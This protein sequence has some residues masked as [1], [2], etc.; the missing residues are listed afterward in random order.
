VPTRTTSCSTAPPSSATTFSS[1]CSVLWLLATWGFGQYISAFN[2]YNVTYGSLGGMVVLLVWLYL[3]DLLFVL[4]GTV[5]AILEHAS[6][7][8]KAQGA[9]A[10]GE[11]PPPGAERPSAVPPGVVASATV[12]ARSAD[13]KRLP[14]EAD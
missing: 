1:R 2:T 9:R 8:G 10:A 7:T 3:S 4:G 11:T 13:E 6:A 14:S 12:A 5:N